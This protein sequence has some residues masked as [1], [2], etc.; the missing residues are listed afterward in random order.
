MPT[1]VIAGDQDVGMPVEMARAIQI[2]I[3]GAQLAVPP[4]AAHLSNLEHPEAFGRLFA[5]FL[6]ADHQQ[7]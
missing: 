7:R 3:A 5:D 1:L 6:G 2:G 4:R